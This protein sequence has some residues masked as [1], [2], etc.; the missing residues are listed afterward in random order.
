MNPETRTP[1]ENLRRILAYREG[2]GVYCEQRRTRL[3]LSILYIPVSSKQKECFNSSCGVDW[4][5]RSQRKTPTAYNPRK[6][7]YDN[8]RR[9][10]S[11]LDRSLFFGIS[12]NQRGITVSKEKTNISICRNCKQ[13][14]IAEYVMTKNRVRW[15]YK[16]PD[17]S[18][19]IC[20]ELNND[21]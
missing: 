9:I 21:N 7:G 8:P 6:A 15:K 12:H 14:I 1:Q 17:G 13:Q 4:C 11:T 18:K 2:Y 20:R 16:N 10:N 3:I 5:V 19:H